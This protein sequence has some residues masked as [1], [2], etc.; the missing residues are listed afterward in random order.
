MTVNHQNLTIMKNL[1][2]TSILFAFA[3]QVIAQPFVQRKIQLVILF[4]TSNSM[5]GLIDQAKSRI[6]AIVNETSGLRYQG[7]TP[8]LEI[9]MYDYGNSSLSAE[10]Q[11]IRQQIPF[12]S[13]L[14][15]VSEKLFSLRT[16]GGS[17]YCGAVIQKSLLDLNWSLDPKDLKMI[18]IAGNEPFTQGPVDY[19]KACEIAV[20]KNVFINTIHCGSYEQGV[21]DFWKDGATCSKGDYFHIS[22]DEKIQ[23]IPT[24][25]DQ[26]INRLN[27]ELNKTYLWYG[28][29]GVE[30]M[31]K[32]KSED[33]NALQQGAS[34][35]AER[36]MVKSKSIYNNAS[37]DLVDAMNADSTVLL[38]MKDQELP[39]EIRGKSKEVQEKYIEQKSKERSEIQK[40]IQ[41]L[42]IEREEFIQKEK[43]KTNT[44]KGKDDFGT[45]VSKSIQEKSKSLGFE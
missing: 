8:Y 12:T 18:Y 43:A 3:F 32:Q 33:A 27:T 20:S 1:F 36:S 15:L 38:K 26:E 34:V 14:D 10:S 5:D 28:S 42:A 13:D 44:S 25:Y 4:D 30:K 6:W 31:A 22:S 40:N 21:R 19:K 35:A 17:E 37:Y 23:Q 11:Y 45:A 7:I 9:A 41:K 39:E 2:L 24:P 16:N 29:K